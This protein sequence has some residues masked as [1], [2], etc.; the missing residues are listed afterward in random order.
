MLFMIVERFTDNDMLPVYKRLRDAG[1]L[2]PE[3]LKYL[4]SWVEPNF[5]RCFQLMECDDVRLFQ[6]W[7]LEWRGFGVSLE[8]VPVVGSAD[9]QAVVA[10]YLDKAGP[11]P[12]LRGD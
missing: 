1:R 10:P 12:R 2:F 11:A 9:T 5:S 4:D 7:V 6:Q 3:G 8:I